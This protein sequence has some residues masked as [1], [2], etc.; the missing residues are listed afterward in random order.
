V[1]Q[2]PVDR[3]ALNR[4]LDALG[5]TTKH[6]SSPSAAQGNRG[7]AE[8]VIDQHANAPEGAALDD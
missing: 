6:L 8:D 7:N 1:L 5:L 4:A 3:Q 2:K